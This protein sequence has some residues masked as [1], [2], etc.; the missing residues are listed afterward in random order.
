L[1]LEVNGLK[2]AGQMQAIE[3]LT[4]FLYVVMGAA[5]TAVRIE[6][7]IGNCI[8]GDVVDGYQ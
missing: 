1:F 6:R 8:R 4:P 7:E 5:R 2:I 3:S